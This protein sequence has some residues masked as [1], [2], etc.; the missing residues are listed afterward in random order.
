M[1]D[2]SIYA[3]LYEQMITGTMQYLNVK[4]LKC[5]KFDKTTICEPDIIKASAVSSNAPMTLVYTPSGAGKSD[6]VRSR[7]N[8][9][10][11]NGVPA[12]KIAVLNMNIAKCKQMSVAF[13]TFISCPIFIC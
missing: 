12:E 13:L 10:L 1:K 11:S 6:I 2:Q 4:N 7:V 8:A 3:N 5:F 9:L